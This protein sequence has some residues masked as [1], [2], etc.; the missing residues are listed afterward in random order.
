MNRR[1]KNVEHYEE[2]GFLPNPFP[3]GWEQFQTSNYLLSALR[4]DEFQAINVC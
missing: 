4:E 3:K 1:E 2:L